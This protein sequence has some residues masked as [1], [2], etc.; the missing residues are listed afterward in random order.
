LNVLIPDVTQ[1]ASSIVA[2]ARRFRVVAS[3]LLPPL[4]P[5]IRLVVS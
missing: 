2:I 3:E 4:A 5:G 1:L